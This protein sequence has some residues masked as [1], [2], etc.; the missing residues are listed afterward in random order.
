M[1]KR[2]SVFLTAAVIA[3][4]VSAQSLQ[5]QLH[6]QS[7]PVALAEAQD[8][9]TPLDEGETWIARRWVHRGE[10]KLECTHIAGFPEFDLPI[11]RRVGLIR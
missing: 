11:A 7:Q 6:D 5:T 10:L 2:L 1:N 4:L 9:P 8:C 3:L